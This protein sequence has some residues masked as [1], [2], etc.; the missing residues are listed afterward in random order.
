[1]IQL[2]RLKKIKISPT[3]YKLQNKNTKSKL[4]DYI[5]KLT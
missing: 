2:Y 1:M 4:S 5:Q 3:C